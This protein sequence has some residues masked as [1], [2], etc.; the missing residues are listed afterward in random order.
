MRSDMRAQTGTPTRP[1][2][3]LADASGGE[4]SASRCTLDVNENLLVISEMLN[5]VIVVK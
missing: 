5:C 2:Q 1:P 4:G 3:H